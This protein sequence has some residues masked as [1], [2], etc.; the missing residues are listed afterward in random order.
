MVELLMVISIMIIVISM[1]LPAANGL[2]NAARE[3]QRTGKL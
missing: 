3:L 1:I 2:W